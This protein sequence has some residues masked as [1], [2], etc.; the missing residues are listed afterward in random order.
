MC[1]EINKMKSLTH[2]KN[3]SVWENYQIQ[4][5]RTLKTW[6]FWT[7]GRNSVGALLGHF[8]GT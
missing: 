4:K 2:G 6:D 3:D 5:Q 7:Q 1:P 8:V